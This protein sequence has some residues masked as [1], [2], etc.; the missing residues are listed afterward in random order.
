VLSVNDKVIRPLALRA[1]AS[2]MAWP[3]ELETPRR[4]GFA[5]TLL[6]KNSATEWSRGRSE[7]RPSVHAPGSGR[8]ASRVVIGN[9]DRGGTPVLMPAP[10]GWSDYRL[11]KSPLDDGN[12]TATYNRVCRR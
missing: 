7:C 10:I 9:R 8:A 11:L 12:Q 1:I 2:W 3:S 4:P 5:P 6:L